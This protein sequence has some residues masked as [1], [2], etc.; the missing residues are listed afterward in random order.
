[1]D[2]FA[3]LPIERFVLIIA[4]V[5]SFL[6][7]SLPSLVVTIVAGPALLALQ[8][9]PSPWLLIII[10]LCTLSLAGVG[11]LLGLIGRTRG[12]SLNLGFI[13]TL[14]LTAMGPVVIPPDRLPALLRVLGRLCRQRMRPRPSGRRSSGR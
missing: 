7:L 6:L 1:M 10:P 14:L 5:L 3:T 4:M 2:Y 8:L 12:D 13:F 11:G 9:R